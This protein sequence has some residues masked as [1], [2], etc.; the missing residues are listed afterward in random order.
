MNRNNY[1]KNNVNNAKVNDNNDNNFNNNSYN[2]VKLTLIIII[3]SC[4]KTLI[5]AKQGVQ[6]LASVCF[7][8]INRL[9]WTYKT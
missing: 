1:K 4:N 3:N 2:N 7:L 9:W 8:C 6:G 5:A